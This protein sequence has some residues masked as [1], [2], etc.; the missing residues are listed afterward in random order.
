[1]VA[2][3]KVIFD[4]SAVGL[5]VNTGSSSFRNCVGEDKFRLKSKQSR[6]VIDFELGFHQ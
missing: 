6:I 2:V 5:V 4:G 1:V 3:V